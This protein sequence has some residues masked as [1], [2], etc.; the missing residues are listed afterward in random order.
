MRRRRRART[1]FA[2]DKSKGKSKTRELKLEKDEKSSTKKHESRD[3][4]DVQSAEENKSFAD[5][6]CR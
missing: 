4:L 5:D 1:R 2:R 3:V 6:S